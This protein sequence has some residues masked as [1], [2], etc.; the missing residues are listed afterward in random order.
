MLQLRQDRIEAQRQLELEQNR[1]KT[2]SERQYEAAI[3]AKYDKQR[4]DAVKAFNTE[5]A[6]L[7]VQRLQA[8]Q[9]AIQLEI[10]ITEDGTDRMLELRLANI[11]KQREI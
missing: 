6:K 10:A 4:L 8:E 3:N 5:I 7:N 1:Q 9:Q 11:E 2:E